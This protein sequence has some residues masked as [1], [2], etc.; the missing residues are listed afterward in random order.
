MKTLG[1]TLIILLAAFIV[2]GV[3]RSPGQRGAVIQL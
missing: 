3:N 2:I 1:R